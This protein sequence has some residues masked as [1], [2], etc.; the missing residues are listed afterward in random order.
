MWGILIES[1]YSYIFLSTLYK[2]GTG[3][4]IVF[5]FH[6]LLNEPPHLRIIIYSP[7]KMTG[8]S[9]VA[10]LLKNPPPMQETWV[11]SLGWEDP[12]EK[13]KAT[14]SSIL[15]WRI[16]WTTVPGVT[17]SWT[18]LRDFHFQDDYYQKK[19]K[20]TSLGEDLWK[21]QLLCTIDGNIKWYSCCGK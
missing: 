13:G 1:F 11:R 2:C 4:F 8:T 21:L 6:F 14:H 16:P 12:L 15:A 5:L 17:N 3:F 10:Q 7:I 19:Q 9:L 18:W 20:I